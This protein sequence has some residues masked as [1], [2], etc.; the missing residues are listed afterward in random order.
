MKLIIRSSYWGNVLKGKP[1]VDGANPARSFRTICSQAV[2]TIEGK[3]W[4]C[5]QGQGKRVLE[6]TEQHFMDTYPG[7]WDLYF[8]GSTSNESEAI[9]Q[10][11]LLPQN[12]NSIDVRHHMAYNG[13]QYH[14]T[15]SAIAMRQQ[16]NEL[17]KDVFAPNKNIGFNYHHIH[18]EILM[19]QVV[20][21][22]ARAK[23]VSGKISP[24]T[25]SD[26]S[27]T[28][29]NS[30]PPTPVP[31]IAK[32][33]SN[34]ATATEVTSSPST[35]T[36][37]HEVQ[38]E[39]PQFVHSGSFDQEMICYPVPMPYPVVHTMPPHHAMPPTM[40]HHN[41]MPTYMPMPVGMVPPNAGL[42]PPSAGHVAYHSTG[43]Y[44][45]VMPHSVSKP[46]PQ[47]QQAPSHETPTK[48]TNSPTPTN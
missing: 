24:A 16:L 8:V 40:Y 23:K 38:Q 6:M 31:A 12:Q 28:N 2:L 47:Q 11:Y 7:E 35:C 32:S 29:E 3:Y 4:G 25:T 30:K 27:E 20:D 1:R 18:I 13:W 34:D 5:C 14:G 48:N 45:P 33:A 9:H 22:A 41:Y 19:P 44:P 26:K 43:M 36:S 15:V 39:V 46:P 37:Y 17:L 42:A 21:Y 10:Y